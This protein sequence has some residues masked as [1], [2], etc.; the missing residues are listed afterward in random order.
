LAAWNTEADGTGQNYAPGKAA[1]NILDQDGAEITLYPVWATTVTYHWAIYNG[2]DG[3]LIAENDETVPAVNPEYTINLPTATRDHFELVGFTSDAA[4]VNGTKSF[5]ATGTVTFSGTNAV[6]LAKW[7]SYK[8]KLSDGGTVTEEPIVYGET[9][10]LPI[11]SRSGYDF[12]G[13]YT[14]S[15]EHAGIT[16]SQ[17]VTTATGTIAAEI[18]GITESDG[19]EGYRFNIADNDH[20]VYARWRKAETLYIQDND[21]YGD[22][23]IV[24]DDSKL[25][26]WHIETQNGIPSTWASDI[27]TTKVSDGGIKYYYQNGGGYDP[28]SDDRRFFTAD[29]KGEVKPLN[30]QSDGKYVTTYNNG[31]TVYLRYAKGNTSGGNTDIDGFQVQNTN[32][33]L[34]YFPCDY[35][36]DTDKDKTIIPG[37]YLYGYRNGK[38]FYA[39]VEADNSIIAVEKDKEKSIAALYKETP[40]YSYYD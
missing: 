29:D 3:T 18:A 36:G 7:D 2:Y 32:D 35:S 23:Y 26:N 16:G 20:T 9:I 24:F 27:T 39:K 14:D 38:N 40:V 11:P 37:D 30:K 10:K 4:D 6:L 13:W 25:M 33:N 19:A 1:P 8:L 34:A 22:V 12:V 21:A 15:I 5:D 28:V 31:T 17:Q